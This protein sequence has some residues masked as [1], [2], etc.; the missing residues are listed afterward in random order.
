MLTPSSFGRDLFDD[1][2]KEPFGSFGHTASEV[3]KTDIKDT[4]RGYEI[5]INLPGVKKEDVNAE[6]KDGY[7][8]IQANY[9]SDNEDKNSDGSY[10]RR[11]RYYGTCSRSFYVGDQ[12][13]E[14]D[15]KAKFENGTLKLTVPKVDEQPKVEN[16]K[17]IAIE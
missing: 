10:I 15:I 6:L 13:K 5:T 11:E 9:R 1:F 12:V 17:Y 8:T 4:S 2:F 7:M 3:M 14:E 16:K